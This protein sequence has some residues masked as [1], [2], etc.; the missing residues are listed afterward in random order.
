MRSFLLTLL[1]ALLLLASPLRAQSGSSSL[2]PTLDCGLY[3]LSNQ[4]LHSVFVTVSP[5][6]LFAMTD[7]NVAPIT[8]VTPASNQLV[9]PW[10]VGIYYLP[11]SLAYN[12]SL[13]QYGVYY[14]NTTHMMS[15]TSDTPNDLHF[16]TYIQNLNFGFPGKLKGPTKGMLGKPLVWGM[17]YRDVAVLTQGDGGVRIDLQ[18]F[19]ITIP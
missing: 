14:A 4:V 12:D 10:N 13:S 6:Q 7:V 8:L 9:C 3:N 17:N 2:P 1:A 11:H 15:F 19:L 16:N 5:P 18:Y